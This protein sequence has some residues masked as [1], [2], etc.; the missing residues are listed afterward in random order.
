MLNLR[1]KKR[2]EAE[3]NSTKDVSVLYKLMSNAVYGKI[4][5]ILGSRIDV[6]LVNNEND[7]AKWT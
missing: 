7:Y 3:K 6:K 5:E 4:M 1:C 2:I